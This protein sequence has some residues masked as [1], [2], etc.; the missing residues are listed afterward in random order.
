MTEMIAL[1]LLIPTAMLTKYPGLMMVIVMVEYT[2]QKSVRMMVGIALLFGKGTQTVKWTTQQGSMTQ[3]VM[4]EYTI[5]KSVR[6]MVGI[7]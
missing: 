5:Q 6:M 7:A 3:N 4:V 1:I 2:I